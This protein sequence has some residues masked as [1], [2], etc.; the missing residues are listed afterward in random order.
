MKMIDHFNKNCIHN[1]CGRHPG[2][3][4]KTFVE[5]LLHEDPQEPERTKLSAGSGVTGSGAKLVVTDSVQLMY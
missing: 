2:S 5:K 1:D 3:E 4:G